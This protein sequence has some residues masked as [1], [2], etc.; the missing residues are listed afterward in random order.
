MLSI[1]TIAM[2]L[3]YTDISSLHKQLLLSSPVKT[4]E[5]Y[6]VYEILGFIYYKIVLIVK[7]LFQGNLRLA[8]V[9]AKTFLPD[10]KT[11]DTYENQLTIALSF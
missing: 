6:R 11:C 1:L 5:K 3:L 2:Y 9:V 7:M 4:V 10:K 8:T